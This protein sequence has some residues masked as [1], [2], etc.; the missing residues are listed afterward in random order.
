MPFARKQIILEADSLSY[1]GFNSPVATKL[2]DQEKESQ[3]KSDKNVVSFAV[4]DCFANKNPN[5][6]FLIVSWTK[7]GKGLFRVQGGKRSIS[8]PL[9]INLSH[10]SCISDGWLP[11]V[12]TAFLGYHF[13][14]ICL[15]ELISKFPPTQFLLWPPCSDLVQCHQ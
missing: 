10:L 14:L 6:S 3:F 1:M 4:I 2:R 9:K 8:W 5:W 13:F 11:L 15:D 7:E 12:L